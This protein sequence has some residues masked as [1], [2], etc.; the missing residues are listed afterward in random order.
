MGLP[1][2]PRLIDGILVFVGVELVAVGGALFG[3]SAAEWLPA[4]LLYLA[5]GAFLLLALRASLAAAQPHWIAAALLSSLL[6]HAGLLGWWLWTQPLLE[7]R[8]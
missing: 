5:S 3:S 4:W 6:A 7:A 8:S 2:G 1:V